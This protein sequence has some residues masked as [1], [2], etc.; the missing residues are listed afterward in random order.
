MKKAVIYTRVSSEEQIK[1]NSLSEQEKK[2]RY[3]IKAK[4]AEI[5]DVYEDGGRGGETK[6]RPMLQK[7]LEDAK[8][9]KFDAVVVYKI[10]RL[11]RSLRDFL[12]MQDYFS[13]LNIELI[14]ITEAYDTSTP[15]GRLFVNMLGSFAEFEREQ[16]KDRI[17]MGQMASMKKGNW[18]GSAP[19]G[20][21][22]KDKKLVINKKEA[23]VVKK[24]FKMFADNCYELDRLTLG[25]AQKIVNGWKVP[26]KK[27]K[28]KNK[29][30]TS[31]TFWCPST[32]RNILKNDV[33]TGETHIRRITKNN[34]PDIKSKRVIRPKEEWI[35]Y[36]A[37]KIISKEI[38]NKAQI[39]LKKNS[40][41]AFRKQKYPEAVL[42]KLMYC[43]ECGRKYAVYRKN[44]KEYNYYFCYCQG[45]KDYRT[46]KKCF[47][48]T[49]VS[50]R[51]E[52]PV[53]E[54][55]KEMLLNP[56]VLR[57][58]IEKQVSGHKEGVD[59]MYIK[60]LELRLKKIKAQKERLLNLYLVGDITRDKFKEKE[61]SINKQEDSI[62]N[63]INKI[64]QNKIL[65]EGLIKKSLD[66]TTLYNKL[67][68]NLDNIS[69]DNK[70]KV[71]RLL[72]DRIE[73]NGEGFAKVSCILPQQVV[74]QTNERVGKFTKL[75]TFC[76]RVRVKQV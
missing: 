10:D 34:N 50:H 66:F 37:P 28:S 19:Y 46:D 57:R 51:L 17:N 31:A 3:F 16:I 42:S 43:S 7:L 61:D 13:K 69:A 4:D 63:E 29:K 15:Q 48:K 26:T 36:V 21:N 2:C 12:E 47:A 33:Y 73:T 72:I 71:F 55:L 22:V 49:F 59:P 75:P 54:K 52:D 20:Y 74:M 60:E 40:E 6:D 27:A 41:F 1:G 76:F 30:K 38:F 18:K 56:D 45:T 24:I 44:N 65:K 64:N 32:I 8:S 62:T 11:S 58:Y 23:E 35:E 67:N 68:I 14:S 53:W 70:R 39:T 25:K 5:I 9:G